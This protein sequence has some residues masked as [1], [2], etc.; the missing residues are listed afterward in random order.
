LTV[1]EIEGLHDIVKQRDC[2]IFVDRNGGK[3]M[4]LL[5]NN[6]MELLKER[7]NEKV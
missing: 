1:I 2:I 3:T 4:L 6:E 7:I 5:T